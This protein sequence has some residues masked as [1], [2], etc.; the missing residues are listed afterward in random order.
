MKSLKVEDIRESSSSPERSIARE[1]PKKERPRPPSIPP[2]TRSTPP[3]APTMPA[4]PSEVADHI[5]GLAQRSWTGSAPIGQLKPHVTDA[6]LSREYLP[7]ECFQDESRRNVF[8]ERFTDERGQINSMPLL[9]WI[10]DRNLGECVD[11]PWKQYLDE[12]LD[13]VIKLEGENRRGE[14]KHGGQVGENLHDY[15]MTEMRKRAGKTCKAFLTRL[16]GTY[17]WTFVTACDEAFQRRLRTEWIEGIRQISNPA[18]VSEAIGDF[19][20]F[21]E[22]F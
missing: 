8:C 2:S 19:F 7:A 14:I 9:Q 12:V 17:E 6:Y 21:Y 1:L 11:L 3:A 4:M 20:E 13:L 18:R 5:I 22:L 15:G 16:N 10:F